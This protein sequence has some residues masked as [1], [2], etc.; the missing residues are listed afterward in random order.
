MGEI[1]VII[2]IIISDF[3]NYSPFLLWLCLLASPCAGPTEVILENAGPGWVGTASVVQMD[4]H[5]GLA[6]PGVSSAT[7]VIPHPKSFGSVHALAGETN[8]MGV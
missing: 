8:I 1:I 4:G 5:G 2:N 3:K 7:K 6:H